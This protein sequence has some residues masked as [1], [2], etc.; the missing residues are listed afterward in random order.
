MIQIKKLVFGRREKKVK[1]RDHKRHTYKRKLKK[2]EGNT[3]KQKINSLH[4][5]N[6]IYRAF[7][8]LLFIQKGDAAGTRGILNAQFFPSNTE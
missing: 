3:C 5:K 4:T 8:C 6:V 2:Y 7:L 1:S